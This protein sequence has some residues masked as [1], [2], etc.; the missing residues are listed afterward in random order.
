MNPYICVTYAHEDRE[1]SDSFCRGL[2]RYG[3]R[4]SCVNELGEPMRRVDL[5]NQAE[6]LIAL[7]SP[8]AARAET[9]ASD[10]RHAL[11]H[12]SRVLCVS[13]SAMKI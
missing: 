10:I 9:V 7:T 12:G 5:L 11:E 6:L 3:F 2:A 4:Y 13:I 1:L 8:A